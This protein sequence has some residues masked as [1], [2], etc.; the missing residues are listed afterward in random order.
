[1][2]AQSA[3]RFCCLH[4]KLIGGVG[5]AVVFVFDDVQDGQRGCCARRQAMPSGEVMSRRPRTNTAGM[6]VMRWCAR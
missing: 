5:S 6:V 3:K 1:M 4:E 2:G